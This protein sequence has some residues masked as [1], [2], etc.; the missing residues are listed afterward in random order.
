MLKNHTFADLSFVS[1]NDEAR[2]WWT[3]ERSDDYGHACAMGREYAKEFLLHCEQLGDRGETGSMLNR[4]M[5][6]M[7][8]SG[9]YGGV[10]VAFCQAIGERII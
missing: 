2:C 10:E 5:A 4:I 1:W 7:V 8:A 3:P 6:A 9:V